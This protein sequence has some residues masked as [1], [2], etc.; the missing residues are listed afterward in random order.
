MHRDLKPANIMISQGQLKV[1]DFGASRF[2][3]GDL[4]KTPAGTPYYK[5]PE[6]LNN[7]EYSFN[8]DMWSAGVILF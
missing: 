7:Q 3:E 4:L 2:F 6:L 1:T 5:S 8:V